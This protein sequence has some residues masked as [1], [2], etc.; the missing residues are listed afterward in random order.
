MQIDAQ[1]FLDMV[2]ESGK[3]CFFDTESTGLKGDYNSILVGSVKPFGQKPKSFVT[4]QPGNDQRT[5]REF[6][7]ELEKYLCWVSYYGKGFDIK[8]INTRRT[9]WGIAP[10]ENRHHVDMYFTLKK[11]LI[12]GRRS[13][14]HLLRFFNCSAQKM[15]VSPEHW[16]E[17][18]ADPK[19]NMPTM[20]ARCESDTEGLEAL[21][22]KTR[23]LIRDIKCG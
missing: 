17:V 9:R 6:G 2:E 20:I 14:A 11:N 12:T 3:L 8:L 23:H 15:D 7:E 4:L 22:R 21:Y 5:C 18:I 10:V 13:Q 19:K 16:N 1:S